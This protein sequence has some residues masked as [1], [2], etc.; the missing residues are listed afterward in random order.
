[1]LF[2]RHHGVFTIAPSA[3][4][5]FYDLYW[6]EKACKAQIDIQKMG[7]DLKKCA[8]SDEAALKMFRTTENLESPHPPG[9]LSLDT[10]HCDLQF[11]AYKE[12][13]GL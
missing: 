8:M 5:A 9:P 13:L 1:M 12:S 6:I 10:F 3:A 7:E 11:N 2:H 4:Q